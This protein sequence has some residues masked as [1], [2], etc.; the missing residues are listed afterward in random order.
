MSS[1]F[2]SG[3]FSFLYKQAE[4]HKEDLQNI[5]M[6]QVTKLK[7]SD[8]IHRDLAKLKADIKQG[9]TKFS[10]LA[11]QWYK[12]FKNEVK[13]AEDKAIFQ[14]SLLRL[15]N[16]MHDSVDSEIRAKKD[17]LGQLAIKALKWLASWFASDP[18]SNFEPM[19]KHI[20]DFFFGFNYQYA[21][22]KSKIKAAKNQQDI[23]NINKEIGRIQ[24]NIIAK[25]NPLQKEIE[26]Y[27][28]IKY[29]ETQICFKDYFDKC[30]ELK[31]SDAKQACENLVSNMPT[32]MVFF[33]VLSSLAGVRSPLAN[34]AEPP[35]KSG[36]E[37]GQGALAKM[38]NDAFVKLGQKLNAKRLDI[39]L[40][41]V[42]KS[43]PVSPP[44]LRDEADSVK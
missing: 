41:N 34:G 24:A 11:D 29:A 15:L 17:T 2:G 40:P 33:K 35:S 7:S 44:S 39:E 38:C 31:P 12:K 37:F 1:W 42:P 30:T 43:S 36:G 6:P 28:A 23:D 20:K 18:G 19:L 32:I 25:L 8:S 3:W 27:M 26:K 9:E 21:E 16:E 10:G 5:A 13:K 4:E 22:L 14:E